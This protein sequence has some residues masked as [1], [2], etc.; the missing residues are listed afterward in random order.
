MYAIVEIGGKQ[1][2]VAKDQSLKVPKINADSGSSVSFDRVLFFSDDAGKNQFGQPLVNGIMISATVV[3]HGRD[4]KII[5]FKKK[6]RKG[7]QVKNGHRQGFTVIK[8]NDIGPAKKASTAEVEEKEAPVA[9]RAVAKKDE[10]AEMKPVSPKAAA[11]Q[12]ADGEKKAAKPKTAK[13]VKA[14]KT[15][16]PSEG[17]EA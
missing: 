12:K 2:R 5:V 6:R 8:I 13:T 9:K 10:A 14:K 3:E 15:T 16:T 7:Y 17:K 11:P 4:K 1:F